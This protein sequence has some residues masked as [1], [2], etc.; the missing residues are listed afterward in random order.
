MILENH[1]VIFDLETGGLDTVDPVVLEIGA[2]VLDPKTLTVIPDA[3]FE[4]LVIPPDWSKVSDAALKVNKITK[5][6]VY[7]K[8]I[9]EKDALTLFINFCKQYAVND[10]K[11]KRVIPAGHNI[12]KF[13]IPIMYSLCRKYGLYDKD[14]SPKLFHPMLAF[15][16]INLLHGWFENSYEPSSYGMD[17]LRDWFGLEKDG[18]HRAFK[19]ISDCALV[20]PRFLK[21]QR[22]IQQKHKPKFKGCFRAVQN[23][24]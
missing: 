2:I 18:A 5:E 16:T 17:N 6:E 1:I 12:C 14:G 13:D 10:N 24:E 21:F 15:D 8:G 11:W 3:K 20:L 9:P 7:E 22:T 19:D 23:S 4:Q